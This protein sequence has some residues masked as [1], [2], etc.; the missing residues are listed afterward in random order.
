[1]ECGLCVCWCLEEGC[2][3]CARWVCGFV[4]VRVFGVKGVLWVSGTYEMCWC[5]G[6]DVCVGLCV[7]NG[8]WLCC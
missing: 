1:M 7:C 2:F 3:W 6:V 8:V 5:V 4:G